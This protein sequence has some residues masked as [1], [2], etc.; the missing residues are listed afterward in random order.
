[1]TYNLQLNSIP[2]FPIDALPPTIRDATEQ[3]IQVT[4]AP[5]ALVASSALAAASLAVQTKFDVER[6]N[7]LS[8]PC[9]L[10]F[11][12]IAD[13][14]ERKTTVDALFLS[15]AREF[16]EKAS[17]ENQSIVSVLVGDC[18][19]AGAI[20]HMHKFSSSVCLCE[21]EA[22]RILSSN[23]INDLGLLNKAWGGNRITVDRKHERFVVLS[24]RCSLTWMVQPS[25]FSK[26]L[27]RRG[28]NA[29]GIGFLARCLVSYPQSTQGYR[30]R[31]NRP[32]ELVDINRFQQRSLELLNEQL[33]LFIPGKGQEKSKKI[34]LTFSCQAQTEWEN[35]YDEIER[36]SGVGGVFCQ[37]RDYAS[38][39]AENIA[40]MAGIFH[41]FERCEGT[42]ISSEMLSAAAKI[43][44]WFAN[45]F[46]RLF[47][48]QGPIDIIHDHAIRLDNWLIEYAMRTKAISVSKSIL[49]RYGP[50]ILRNRDMLEIALQRLAET[51]RVSY[52][53]THMYLNNRT[54]RKPTQML[55]LHDNYYGQIVRGQQVFGI[56]PL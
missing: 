49:L 41:A 16:E 50:N 28:D 32:R 45:E 30:F 53:P 56:L 46:L 19:P 2:P 29:R 27:E 9:S 11:I 35:I 6:L 44:L 7:G 15:A 24:P 33:E 42:Q 38:K 1:M 39:I 55:L 17:R 8:G 22:G 21:D 37:N 47:T 23:M 25:V 13:S 31:K 3:T 52:F 36:A 14:G 51:N 10:Y 54:S 5:P 34:N 4:E 43:V 12:T 20:A 26:F 18:T 40:R 48:P